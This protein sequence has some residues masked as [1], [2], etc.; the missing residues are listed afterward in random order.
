MLPPWHWLIYNAYWGRTRDGR[1]ISTEYNDDPDYSLALFN[2]L[3][4]WFRARLLETFEF[5]FLLLNFSANAANFSNCLLVARLLEKL[6]KLCGNLQLR[7]SA[8]GK[9]NCDSKEFPSKTWFLSKLHKFQFN[10]LTFFKMISI[11]F[12]LFFFYC[13]I[14]N[15]R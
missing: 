7:L 8:I 3:N 5:A 12:H 2:Y 13:A 11:L 10:F 15:Q 6:R 14:F 4:L 9:K 1:K